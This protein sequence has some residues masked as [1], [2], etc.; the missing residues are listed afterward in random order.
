MIKNNDKILFQGTEAKININIEPIDGVTMDDYSFSV[1][2]YC[3]PNGNILSFKKNDLI[4]VDENNYIARVDTTKL[5]TGVI[6]VKIMADIPDNDFSDGYRTEVTYINTGINLK[7]E[8][9]IER[10]WG[11]SV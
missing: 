6:K 4:R 8:K 9:Y 2:I 5:D 3:N 1:D 11:V 7:N 10:P